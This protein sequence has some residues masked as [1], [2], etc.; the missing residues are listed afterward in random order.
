MQSIFCFVNTPGTTLCIIGAGVGNSSKRF[1]HHRQGWCWGGPDSVKAVIRRGPAEHVVASSSL[2][3]WLEGVTAANILQNMLA[4]YDA[5][6]QNF[7]HQALFD[8]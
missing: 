2:C 1:P 6:V 7:Q 8:V 5:G 3:C 4:A